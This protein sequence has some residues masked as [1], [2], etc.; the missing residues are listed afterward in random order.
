VGL[1]VIVVWLSLVS[2]DTPSFSTVNG[3]F[4]SSES[5]LTSAAFVCWILLLLSVSK[6][7]EGAGTSFIFIYYFIL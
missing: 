5:L 2:F 7:D 6:D 1:L 4:V 3:T